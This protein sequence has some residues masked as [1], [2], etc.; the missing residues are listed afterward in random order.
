[1]HRFEI[2]ELNCTRRKLK[3]GNLIPQN[4]IKTSYRRRR[5]R[6]T[7]IILFLGIDSHP[8]AQAQAFCGYETNKN[9]I[10]YQLLPANGSN[11][12]V[13]PGREV[14]YG[15]KS[16]ELLSQNWQ[17]FV[18]DFSLALTVSSF[19]SVLSLPCNVFVKHINCGVFEH[20]VS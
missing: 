15:A 5:D 13:R 3:R 11:V 4:V 2:K 1:M 18:G 19:Y 17:S 8:K 14:L 9:K 20:I 7:V 10:K 6:S 16:V 12:R